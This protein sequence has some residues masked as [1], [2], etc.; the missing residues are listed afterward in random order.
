[1]KIASVQTDWLSG[2]VCVQHDATPTFIIKCF[3]PAIQYAMRAG[4]L[5]EESRRAW[6]NVMHTTAHAIA[7]A[8]AAMGYQVSFMELT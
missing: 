7:D 6:C 4:K 8:L 1:M 3:P 2:V 5:S